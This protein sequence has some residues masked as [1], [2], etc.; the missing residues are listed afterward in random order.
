LLLA[1]MAIGAAVARS[2]L[3]YRGAVE[4][5]RRL[6]ASHR[7]RC[8]TLG[9]LGMVLSPGMPDPAGRLLL[10]T[11][12]AQDIS[13]TLRYPNRSGGSA[14]LAL[15]TYIGFGM[16]GALFLTGSTGG[17]LAYGLMPPETRA[18]MDW[19]HWFM[20][21][22]P[23]C[24][25]LFGLSMA[26]LLTR[27]RPEGDDDL[28]EATLALQRR[29]LGPLSRDERSGL[30][31]LAALL[32]GFS[33][34]SLHGIE[35]AWLAVGAVVV[36]YLLGALDD[37]TVKTGVNLDFLVYVGVL[38]R[39][40]GVFTHVGLDRWLSD[41]LGSVTGLIGGSALRCL[42]VVAAISA[43]TGI[44]LRPS[45][46]ALLLGVALFPTAAT[47]GVDPWVVMFTVML[48][49]N[50]WLYPQ[51]NVLYQAAYFATGERAFSHEQARPLAFTYGVFVLI[52]LL[53]SLPYWRW[54]GL[55]A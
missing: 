13:D 12:L 32:A 43:A 15:S 46:I 26:F 42:L 40:G 4:L 2:G 50:L 8:L 55:I 28:P 7:I 44:A 3:L 16:M 14:G 29:V 19:V 34:Q 27:Y 23:T 38:L 11:P 21:A 51:Q 20:A 10:A 24:L 5:V 25:I 45:P 52:A 9:G 30:V 18:K 47:A 31:V 35:P 1:S 22:L 37:A 48:T 36:L 49:N 17:L 39:F 33:T 6:P 54:L 53:A 41:Q